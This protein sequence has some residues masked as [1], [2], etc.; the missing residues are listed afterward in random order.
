MDKLIK[1]RTKIN[2]PGLQYFIETIVPEF[3]PRMKNIS[4]IDFADRIFSEY[5]RL[6]Y[7][8]PEDGMVQCCTCW[9]RFHRTKIQNGHYKKRSW[10]KYRFDI[11]NCHPQCEKCNL[12]LEWN[13]RNYHIFMVN[14]YGEEEEKRIREDEST[15]KLYDYDLIMQCVNRYQENLK[16]K[17]AITN[18]YTKML[19]S[20][21]NW[22]TASVI[23]NWFT[24]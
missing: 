22:P 6:L 14:T 7:A 5:I 1:Q 24:T 10:Y 20:I 15:V 9:N 19:N 13:Y 21:R 12:R 18:S 4:M 17:A 23:S 8:R 11:H 3:Y 2:P 16:R